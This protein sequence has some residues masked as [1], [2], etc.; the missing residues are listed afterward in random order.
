M[1]PLM[2][3]GFWEEETGRKTLFNSEHI[4]FYVIVSE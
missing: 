2:E 4:G 1:V 3:E